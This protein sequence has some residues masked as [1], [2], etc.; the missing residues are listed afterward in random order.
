LN[1]VSTSERGIPSHHPCGGSL[2]PT[3]VA[4]CVC[5]SV[6]ER[7]ERAAYLLGP[8][9]RFR[10]FARKIW[11]RPREGRESCSS[12]F[13]TTTCLNRAIAWGCESCSSLNPLCGGIA[14]VWEYRES[15]SLLSSLPP[16]SIG[17][18]GGAN[19]VRLCPLF[20]GFFVV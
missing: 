6:R 2:P 15:C 5:V 9:I 7:T 16:A 17:L 10:R 13:L 3:S 14:C 4:V 1:N 8:R 18:F 20:G 19:H 12:L 11:A